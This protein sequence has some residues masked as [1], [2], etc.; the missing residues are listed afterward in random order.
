MKIGEVTA[1]KT[2]AETKQGTR[3]GCSPSVF[4]TVIDDG[5]AGD[6]ALLAAELNDLNERR[7]DLNRWL[8]AYTGK[9]STSC[10]DSTGTSSSV[11]QAEITS[12]PF[13]G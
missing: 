13:L 5:I 3:N 12:L 10:V 9:R 2:L 8:T 4:N 1:A 6:I 7:A 11:Y